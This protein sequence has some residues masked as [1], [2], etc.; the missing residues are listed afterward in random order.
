M[1]E[2][3]PILEDKYR[4]VKNKDIGKCQCG[5]NIIQ[6]CLIKNNNTNYICWIGNECIERFDGKH[7]NKMEVNRTK[8]IIKYLNNIEDAVKIDK[9]IKLLTTD[10]TETKGDI[11]NDTATIFDN[12][13]NR[14][15]I[16]NEDLKELYKICKIPNEKQMNI[17]QHYPVFHDVIENL[18]TNYNKRII[19]TKRN[20]EYYI[21]LD[22]MKELN[23]VIK[24]NLK[25]H[26][27]YTSYIDSIDIHTIVLNQ[28]N[29]N[30]KHD[31]LDHN[32]PSENNK[33]Y[34]KDINNLSWK[35]VRETRFCPCCQDEF[36]VSIPAQSNLMLCKTCYVKDYLDT[37]VTPLLKVKIRIKESQPIVNNYNITNIMMTNWI[38][39]EPLYVPIRCNEENCKN[40]GQEKCNINTLKKLTSYSCW[41]CNFV[42]FLKGNDYYKLFDFPRQ[43]LKPPIKTSFSDIGILSYKCKKCNRIKTKPVDMKSLLRKGWNV[44]YH[45]LCLEC[46]KKK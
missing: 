37:E 22:T 42:K 25:L 13:N 35:L 15:P 31:Y 20:G 21:N 9:K 33:H 2:I 28:G 19:T 36:D 10:K 18:E 12:L 41:R 32:K 26:S 14:E 5:Q 27:K 1:E 29:E 38:C 8:S 11:F 4:F 17:L 40:Y 7:L 46:Y 16:P 30:L 39:T 44:K 3:V 24:M 45:D 34:H 23:D 6:H 43:K